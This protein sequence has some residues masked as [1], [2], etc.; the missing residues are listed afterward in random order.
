MIAFFE[1]KFLNEDKIKISPFSSGFQY[2]KGFFTTLKYQ[3][4]TAIYL[5]DHLNRLQYSL[6]TYKM[7][8]PIL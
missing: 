2:G 6:S 3:N 5:E 8:F 7:R 4:K 1:E